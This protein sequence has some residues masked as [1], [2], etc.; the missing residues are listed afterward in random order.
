MK[1]ILI[2]VA[3]YG[4]LGY[5]H[6]VEPCSPVQVNKMLTDLLADFEEFVEDTNGRGLAL[7]GR[8]DSAEER[9]DVAES[10]ITSNAADIVIN[11]H[12]VT[13]LHSEIDSVE[14]DFEDF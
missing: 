1:I 14:D 4:L 7:V 11:K 8:L 2:A 13:T 10:N 12:N 9:L 6:I 3:I 5:H